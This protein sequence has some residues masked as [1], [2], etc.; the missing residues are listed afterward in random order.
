M[1]V[2][3]SGPSRLHGRLLGVGRGHGRNLPG[4]DQPR[5]DR[6]TGGWLRS[7][8]RGGSLAETPDSGRLDARTLVAT[9]T[10]SGKSP[11]GR[12]RGRRRRRGG[13]EPRPGPG[14]SAP[15][16]C[17]TTFGPYSRTRSVAL[18][19]TGAADSVAPRPRGRDRHR[20]C[21]RP[22][23]G[24]GSPVATAPSPTR[25][26]AAPPGPPPVPWPG[27]GP[28]PSR[29]PTDN[30]PAVAAVAE[31]ALLGAY[32]F[33]RYRTTSAPPGQGRRQRRRRPHRLGPRR[34]AVRTPSARAEI[35][36]GAVNADPRPRQHPARRPLPGDLRR[37]RVRGRRGPAGH[38]HRPRREGAGRAAGTAASLG[39]GQGSVRPP[40]LVRLDY[41]PG[42]RR[43]A[44]RARRQGHHVRLRRPVDQARRRAWTR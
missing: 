21:R 2:V 39:V 42:R 13:N 19:V 25:P 40:R 41:V 31:G 37:R 6:G 34:N 29:C 16:P 1:P 43:R 4:P 27:P 35:L 17:P 9:L 5:S 26:C 20:A 18:G 32:S 8:E 23:R 12:Q 33:A 28:S 14:F 30:A 11:L 7:G 3:E 10:L 22:H 36:A 15:T 24:R 44:R 38:G